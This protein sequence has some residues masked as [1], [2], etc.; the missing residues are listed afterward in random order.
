MRMLGTLLCALPIASVLAERSAP[1]PYWILL[2]LNVI[3]WPQV[4]VWACRR[5]RDPA[6]AQFRCLA[7]DSAFGGGWIAVMAV[8]FAPSAI[9][10]TMLTA[11]KIVAGGW[12]LL[13]RSTIALVIGFGA[14]WALLGFP[15]QPESSHRTLLLSFPFMFVYTVALSV[16]THR[17]S[18]RITEQNKDLERLN[19][20]DPVMQV[21]NRPHFEAMSTLELSRFH[22]SGRPASMLLVDVDHF[23]SVN[24]RYGHGMGDIVLKRIAGVLRGNVRE[25]DLPARYGGDE[26]AVLLVDTDTERALQVAERIRTEVALQVFEA[27][28]GLTCSLSIGIAETSSEHTTLEAW[29]RTADAALYRAKAAGR[30]R[31]EAA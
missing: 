2:A 10:L 27:E 3:V 11:D 4:A 1:A 19:R 28:P 26:F 29:V 24:D 5:A 25:I 16:L 18:R 9:F 20:T 17:L 13:R 7:A 6:E 21:P 23:K 12:N 14:T 8:S 15:W 31:I 30:D 22:R